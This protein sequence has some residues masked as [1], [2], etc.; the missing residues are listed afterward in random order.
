MSP[1]NFLK[2]YMAQKNP[3]FSVDLIKLLDEMYP[4]IHPEDNITDRELW[5]KIYQRRLVESLKTRY[6]VIDESD[7]D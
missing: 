3:A 4:P 5:G 6:K 7:P 2:D 1:K